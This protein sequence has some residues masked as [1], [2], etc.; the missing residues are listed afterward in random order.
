LLVFS[1]ST[2]ILHR[3]AD[4]QVLAMPS[5]TDDPHFYRIVTDSGY[6]GW[7]VA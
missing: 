5:F 4:G 2:L 7:T 3:V 1:M 6:K